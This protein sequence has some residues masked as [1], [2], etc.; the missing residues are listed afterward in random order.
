MIV[1]FHVLAGAGVAHVGTI[2]LRQT[3]FEPGVRRPGAGLILLASA[4]GLASH[5]V[6][7]GLRHGYPLSAIPDIGLAA[8]LAVIWCLAVRSPL[9]LLF[10][11]VIAAALLPDIVDH[12]AAMLRWK[13]GLDVPMRAPI[14]PWHWPDGSGSLTDRALDVGRNRAVSL[15]NHL[16]VLVLVTGCVLSSLWAFRFVPLTRPSST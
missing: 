13:A 1:V 4:V 14:F 6:L 7:D 15:T 8:T 3:T 12:G 5:G 2:S 9:R 11:C 16:V 10:A